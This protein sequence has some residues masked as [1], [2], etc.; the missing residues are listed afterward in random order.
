MIALGLVQ[1]MDSGHGQVTAAARRMA[2][3]TAG[4]GPGG[5][6]YGPG[7]G[8]LVIRLEWAGGAADSEFMTW[9]SRNI[10]IRGGD[11]A[12]LQRKV[13]FA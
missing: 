12:I 8:P 4:G 3:A 11:P 9:L 1:G 13:K 2:S 6:G 7:G 5:H 10:R